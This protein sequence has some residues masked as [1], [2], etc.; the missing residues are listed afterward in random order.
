MV[1]FSVSVP[2]DLGIEI[3]KKLLFN[4]AEIEYHE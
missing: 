1:M 3:L 2:P 4:A